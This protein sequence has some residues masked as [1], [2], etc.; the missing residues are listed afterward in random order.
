MEK[1]Y[2]YRGFMIIPNKYEDNKMKR[3]TFD[4][5]DIFGKTLNDIKN[6]IDKH[7]GGH[8]TAKISKRFLNQLN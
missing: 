3:T 6:N 1:I 5:S 8:P 7:I 4:S 2:H